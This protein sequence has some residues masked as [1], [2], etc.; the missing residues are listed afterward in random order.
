MRY[1]L[2]EIGTGNRYG[3][4]DTYEEAYNEKININHRIHLAC[5]GDYCVNLGIRKIYK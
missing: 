1:E 3:V 4:F 2:Y 5:G